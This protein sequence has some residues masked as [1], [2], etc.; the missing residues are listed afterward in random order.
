VL[1]A[2]PV[3][4]IHLR[5]A[6]HHH[7]HAVL[8]HRHYEAHHPAGLAATIEQQ[9]DDHGVQ[10]VAS[11]FTSRE[12]SVTGHPPGLVGMAVAGV[13]PPR[14]LAKLFVSSAESAHDPPWAAPFTLRG[15]PS[16][17]A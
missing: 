9:D 11:F 1:A 8:I 4:H 12:T 5:A 3:E 16:F 17:F 14:V 15:P 10:W 2:L 7:D 6:D 13:S